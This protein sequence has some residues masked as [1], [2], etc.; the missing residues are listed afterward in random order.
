MPSTGHCCELK[1]VKKLEALGKPSDSAD[2]DP[3]VAKESGDTRT[4]ALTLE[5]RCL[6]TLGTRWKENSGW[7]A[8]GSLTQHTVL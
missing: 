3:G 6:L 5:I 2:L 1:S 8:E 7:R 4:G